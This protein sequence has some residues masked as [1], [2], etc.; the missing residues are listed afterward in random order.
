MYWYKSE[1]AKRKDI[2]KSV[3]IPTDSQDNPNF[4]MKNEK[5]KI[6]KCRCCQWVL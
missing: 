2:K 1:S 4:L 5:N 3:P 6:P